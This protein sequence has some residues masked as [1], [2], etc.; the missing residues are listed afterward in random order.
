MIG[1]APAAAVVFARDVQRRTQEDPRI[2]KL[3]G[4][5]GAA[6]G[7]EKARLAAELDELQAVVH[8]EKLGE[9][10]EEFDRIHSVQRALDVGSIQHIIPPPE[11]RPYLIAAVE[12]GIAKEVELALRS[13]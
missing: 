10:A 2:K 8:S 4:A 6:L 7:A 3:A 5:V 13:T 1:G 11:L 9:V 12:R